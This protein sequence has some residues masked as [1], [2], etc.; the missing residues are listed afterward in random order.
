MEHN[1]LGVKMVALAG[2]RIF[3]IED[4]PE[5]RIITQITLGGKGAFLN[6]DYYGRNVVSKLR[7]FQPVD[8][9]ILDLMLSLGSSGF[10]VITEIRATEEFKETPIVAVSASD[11]SSAIP[12][13]RQHGFDGF[14]A[15]PITDDFPNQIKRIIAGESIW[16]TGN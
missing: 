6:F 2:K 7:A 4:N 14:I 5:N 9:I 3:V 10:N 13:C 16:D 12:L 15:K 11:P 8:L 1:R